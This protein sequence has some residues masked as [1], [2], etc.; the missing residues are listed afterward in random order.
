MTFSKRFAVR[1]AYGGTIAKNTS[2]DISRED[3]CLVS[4]CLR[5]GGFA[6]NVHQV[7]FSQNNLICQVYSVRPR[8]CL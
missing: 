1:Y 7:T 6:R 4:T 8:S 5:T 3:L 2:A